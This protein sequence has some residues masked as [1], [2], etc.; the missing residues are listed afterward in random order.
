MTTEPEISQ[1][2]TGILANVAAIERSLA[3]TVR[4]ARLQLGA[5]AQAA[6]TLRPVSFEAMG[7]AP[8]LSSDLAECLAALVGKVPMYQGAVP[9][10]QFAS[11]SRIRGLER[12]N[13][14]TFAGSAAGKAT[15]LPTELGYDVARV[16][17]PAAPKED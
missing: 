11:G 10:S 7:I 12:R 14:I 3:E 1:L 6:R 17:L 8:N 2:V 9:S 16:L 15:Y 5:I 13:L 4:M